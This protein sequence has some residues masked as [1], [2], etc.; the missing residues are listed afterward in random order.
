MNAFFQFK[1]LAVAYTKIGAGKVVVLLHGFGEDATIWN[2][3]VEFLKAYFTVITID[4]P[5]SGKSKI[6]G[7][8][9]PKN[10]SELAISDTQITANDLSTIECYADVVNA[11]LIHINIHKCTMLGHSMGGY[12]TLAFAE[13]YAHKLYGFGLIHSTAYADSE[14]KKINRQRGIQ[15]MEQYG[16]YVFL[17]TIIPALFTIAFKNNSPNII[18]ALL[19]KGKL[20]SVV[21]LQNYCLAMMNRIDRTDVLKDGNLPVLFIIG[22]EDI[23]VPIKDSLQQS[24][25]AK[26]SYIHLLDKIGHMG[27]L[28]KPDVVNIYIKNFINDII[29]LT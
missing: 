21:A 19:E 29:L 11:L 2:N 25:M 16:S 3:Q 14:E 22:T 13:K 24:H 9:M 18:D 6:D 12:I 23:A 28:E 15:M 1:N 7:Y 8:E 20:F 17:K 10:G 26:C 4:L 27:M 5:G